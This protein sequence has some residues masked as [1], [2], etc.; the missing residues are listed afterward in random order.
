MD[1]TPW[2]MAAHIASLGLW[3]AALLIMAGLYARPPQEQDRAELHRHAL[4]C[5]YTFMMLGSPAAVLAILTGS[6]LVV[7]RGVEGS[8]LL[9]K[10]AVVAVMALY[11]VYCGHLLHEQQ[12]AALPEPAAWRRVLLLLVPLVFIST[13]F[14]LVLAKPN[15]VLEHQITPQP[16]GNRYQ[17]GAQQGQIQATA[18]NGGEGVVNAG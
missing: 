8:W 2:A 17:Q 15:V 14:V 12:H 16:A 10:L 18:M 11:H 5:R 4:M 13:I 3:S 6:A 1:W 9:A 7:L